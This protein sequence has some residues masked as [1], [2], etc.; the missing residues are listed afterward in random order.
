MTDP[1]LAVGKGSSA[2]T[3]AVFA[4]LVPTSGKG[5]RAVVGSFLYRVSKRTFS[6][7]TRYRTLQPPPPGG[8]LVPMAPPVSTV[9]THGIVPATGP[10]HA[11]LLGLQPT[12]CRRAASAR[13]V[14]A[15]FCWW[16]TSL[17]QQGC[18]W[19]P[20]HDHGMPVRSSTRLSLASPMQVPQ[21][22][23]YT[24]GILYTSNLDNVTSSDFGTKFSVRNLNPQ[25]PREPAMVPAPSPAQSS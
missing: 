13:V 15:R 3:Y 5:S 17:L 19:P 9:S 23:F 14:Q 21:Q 10:G 18:G 25:P 12:P 2:G 7:R 4:L 22:L 24:G 1:A 6:Y 8:D 11:S 16:V 20:Q